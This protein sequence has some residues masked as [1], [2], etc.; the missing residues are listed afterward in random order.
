MLSDDEL[1]KR[2]RMS[3]SNSIRLYSN[4]EQIIDG[5][6]ADL[7]VPR[8]KALNILSDILQNI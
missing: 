4:R 2:A 1:Y 3:I 8:T 7:G 5:L 6:V